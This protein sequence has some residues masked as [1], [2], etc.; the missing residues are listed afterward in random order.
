MASRPRRI[1]PEIGQV[2]MRRPVDPHEH[3]RRS[4]DEEFV[5]AEIDEEGIGRRVDR[6]ELARYRRRRGQAALVERLAGHHLE[7]VAAAELFPGEF[8]HAG[9]FAGRVVAARRIDIGAAERLICRFARQSGG[10]NAA[11][12]VVVAVVPGDGV[13]MVD[14]ED[15]VGQIQHQ[16]AGIGGTLQVQFHIVELKGEIVA[17]SAV[18]AEIGIGVGA[19]QVD[20]GA[21]DRKHRR[22]TRAHFLG[23]DF[24]GRLNRHVDAVGAAR[25][26]GDVLVAGEA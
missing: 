23:N 14:D 15:F 19:E 18:E 7:Q 25:Q 16:V 9:I 17:K 11:E 22:R 12:F 10:R 20:D 21:D 6:L 24:A 13:V 3:F 26:L 5:G 8:D 1:V 2:S 4:A